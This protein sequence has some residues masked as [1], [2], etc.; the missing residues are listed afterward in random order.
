MSRAKAFDMVRQH[1]GTP[2]EAVTRQTNVLVV[3]E[4]GWPSWMTVDHRT[5]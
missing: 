2:S 1:G 4:L 5:S 3:G